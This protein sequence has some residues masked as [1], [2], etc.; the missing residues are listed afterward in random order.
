M[1]LDAKTNLMVPKMKIELLIYPCS[2]R[3]KLSFGTNS[4][5]CILIINVKCNSLNSVYRVS[6]D[7]CANVSL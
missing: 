6:R 4:Q 3:N 7:C 1:S 2:L 5:K